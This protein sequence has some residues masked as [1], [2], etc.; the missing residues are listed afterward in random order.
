MVENWFFFV[1]IRGRVFGT[2]GP[3]AKDRGFESRSYLADHLHVHQTK[4]HL[5]LPI[6]VWIAGDSCTYM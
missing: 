3:G 1:E 4:V 2:F 6:R 5:D